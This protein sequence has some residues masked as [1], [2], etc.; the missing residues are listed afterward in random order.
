MGRDGHTEELTLVAGPGEGWQKTVYDNDTWVGQTVM[1][2]DDNQTSPWQLFVAATDP[3]GFG[4]DGMPETF[5]SYATG[6]GHWQ[7]YEDEN[8]EGTT[9][10]TD[11]HHRLAPTLR[12][13]FLNVFV[14]TPTGGERVVGGLVDR[15]AVLPD[16]VLVADFKTNRRAP[17]RVE[18]TPVM[19]LR[20]MAA[21]RAVLRE[22]F[23]DRS[24]HCWLI[25]THTAQASPL[26]DALLDGHAPD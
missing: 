2:Q 5:A 10:G 1:V 9:G 18:D 12:G 13:D 23:P 17:T 6:T 7:T 4:L 22:V 14:G 19:Y 15:L 21:Y 26:P 8:G 20:Q 11:A 3:L 16:R 24:V 25:W